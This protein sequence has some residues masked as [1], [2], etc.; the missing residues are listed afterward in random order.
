[1]ALIVAAI[2]FPVSRIFGIAAIAIAADVV[3]LVDL[4]PLGWATLQGRRLVP[5]PSMILVD[6]RLCLRRHASAGRRSPEDADSAAA[7]RS[8]PLGADDR[9]RT[10]NLLVK[11][12]A[13]RARA[14]A[15]TP[16][17][18][19]RGTIWGAPGRSRTVSCAFY[20][21]SGYTERSSM[22]RRG[23]DSKPVALAVPLIK[24]YHPHVSSH[25][26]GKI[27]PPAW[28]SARPPQAPG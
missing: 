15:G 3:F 20:A 6:N 22:R 28:P 4:T 24:A 19:G 9:N 5:D 7:R 26:R 10:P 17:Q 23:H 11:A 1:M 27:G 2:L 16:D 18:I 21:C 25:A 12:W 8:V 14:S 13:A